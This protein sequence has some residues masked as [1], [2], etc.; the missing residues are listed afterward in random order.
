ERSSRTS[1][2]STSGHTAV[3]VSLSKYA[4]SQALAPAHADSKSI[5][6]TVGAPWATVSV[7]LGAE[8]APSSRQRALST[9]RADSADGWCGASTC[10][11][12]LRRTRAHGQTLVLRR[13]AV[14]QTGRRR[15]TP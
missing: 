10:P 1:W 3:T 11:A 5:R 13:G 9:L 6:T 14:V 8:L 12:T 4:A 2:R 7:P 15:T